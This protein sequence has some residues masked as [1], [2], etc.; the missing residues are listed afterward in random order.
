M[1]SNLGWVWPKQFDALNSKAKMNVFGVPTMEMP[2]LRPSL[3]Q[4]EWCAARDARLQARRSACVAILN[5]I[6]VACRFPQA[7]CD[8]LSEL[9]RLEQEY[10]AKVQSLVTRNTPRSAAASETRGFR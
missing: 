2:K 9:T 4:R 5:C 7:E 6:S 1:Y 3:V 8:E 10:A